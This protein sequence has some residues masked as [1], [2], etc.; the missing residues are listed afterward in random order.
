MNLLKR[1]LLAFICIPFILIIFYHG[2]ISLL[3]LLGLI[4]F[5][6]GQELRELFLRKGIDLPLMILPLNLMVYAGYIF[7]GL[8]GF[9]AGML[10]IVILLLGRDLFRN[11]IDGAL[12]RAAHGVFLTIY[13]VLFLS[14]LYFIRELPSGRWLV[15]SLLILIWITDTFAYFIG[16][17]LGRKKMLLAASPKKSLAGFL[18]GFI[19]SFIGACFLSSLF[20]FPWPVTLGL[21]VATSMIGQLGDLMES[22]LK[23]DAGI[24]DSSALLPG[25][26]GI[27]DR[28]DSLTLA[29]P[30]FLLF[31]KFVL[32]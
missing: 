8:S 14:S 16:A 1:V 19:G 18:G 11:R 30:F 21:I 4:V 29:A 28:F 22:L 27:L 31:V 10:L 17:T 26:G 13:T 9:M 6:S 7:W 24:K 2:G 15:I 20:D 25:H 3:S 23:R 12:S 5:V 32:Y